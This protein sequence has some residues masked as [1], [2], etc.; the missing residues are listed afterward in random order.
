VGYQLCRGPC[1]G[2]W[3]GLSRQDRCHCV[4]GMYPGGG[5]G[6]WYD[7]IPWRLKTRVLNMVE[8]G[9]GACC[10]KGGGPWE[11]LRAGEI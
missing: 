10:R 1:V 5:G 9:P 7:I 8:N 3:G 2:H 11:D 4:P 6:G